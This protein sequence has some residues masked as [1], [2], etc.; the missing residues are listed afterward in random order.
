MKAL[1]VSTKVALGFTLVTLI[2][3]GAV[4]S[5]IQQVL[6][7]EAISNRVINQ[8]VPTAQTSLMLLNG[9]NHSLAG[10]RGW[11]LLGKKVFKEERQNAWDDEIEPSLYKLNRLSEDWEDP[12]N[13]SRLQYIQGHLKKFQAFQD[14]IE[15]IAQTG[16]NLPANKILIEKAVPLEKKIMDNITIMIE[17]EA[18]IKPSKERSSLLG[19]MAEIEG[20]MSL[21]LVNIES[22]LISGDDKFKARYQVLWAKKTK[23]LQDLERN[24]NLL[25]GK[26]QKAFLELTRARKEFEPLTQ[27]IV[28]IR[29]GEHW[30]QANLWLR[31]KAAPE[32]FAIKKHLNEMV[33]SQNS[34]LIY[35]EN[36]FK[37]RTRFLIVVLLSLLCFTACLPFAASS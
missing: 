27:E 21:I 20:T 7:M 25:T 26:Q 13:I 37:K 3:I 17:I 15:A 2:L 30:N 5:T 12:N 1:S 9:I 28:K 23:S 31:T 14:E 34:L 29:S 24:L 16:E 4:A 6:N 10:L 22:F 35:D 33:A 32:A 8:R 19:I 11:M 18:K 36:D